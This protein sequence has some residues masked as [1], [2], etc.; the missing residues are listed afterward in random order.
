MSDPPRGDPPPGSDPRFSGPP[1]GDTPGGNAGPV[2]PAAGNPPAGYPL[3]A[4][5]P[6][7]AVHRHRWYHSWIW[8]IPVVTL[9]IGGWL[10]WDTLTQRGPLITISFLG[11]EGL[12][13]GQSHV[14]HKDVD[15][16]LVQNIQ[17]SKDLQRVIVTIRMD[18]QALPLL[19]TTAQFWVVK[20]RFFAGSISGLETLLSGGYIE[21]L[22]GAAPGASARDFIGLEDPPVLQTDEA[23]TPFLLHAPRIGSISL[24]SPVF[25]RD[26]EVGQVLGWD[27]ADMADSITI[28]AFVRAPFDRYVHDGSHFWNASGASVQLGPKGI[29][30]QLE[31]LRALILGGVAFDTLPD[32][33]GSPVSTANHNFTLYPDAD[34]AEHASIAENIPCIAY[35]A[36]SAA[37]LAPEAMVSL[38][39]LPV[40]EVTSVYLSYDK[41]ADRVVVAVKFDVEPQRINRLQLPG[42]TDSTGMLG[43]LVHRGLR[44]SIGTS[45]LLTGQQEVAL[46]MQPD[47]PA[48]ELKMDGKILVVPT[49]ESGGLSDLA[50]SASAILAKLENLPFDQ[51]ARNL[52][53]TL[54]GA[55][56]LINN[57][58]LPQAVASLQLTLAELQGLVHRADTGVDPLLKRLPALSQELDEAVRRADT[59]LGSLNAGYGSNSG[60]N[61]DLDHLILQLSDAARSVRVLADLLTRHPEALIRGRTD[62]GPQ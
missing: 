39:G 49:A 19:T 34:T 23:G 11:A 20:P 36:G 35:F 52:N 55:N 40:G 7:A 18:R 17:L 16:G 47:A 6:V 21:L 45:S 9:L 43:V 8:A 30:L 50:K 10:V 1:G 14:R 51:I 5:H 61:V 13:A 42:E 28:H 3:A 27:I 60:V 54:S 46:V 44:A 2:R 4:S 62:Q 59:L 29:Q 33:R 38:R 58:Q 25:Y 53:E 22:P 48:A 12:Q 41:V 32:A 57:E 26:L 24:G 56:K 15:M 31:S 37:G